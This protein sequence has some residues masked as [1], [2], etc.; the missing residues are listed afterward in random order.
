MWLVGF[1][2][3][4]CII[5]SISS[6]FF[7]IAWTST[8]SSLYSE[9]WSLNTALYWSRCSSVRIAGYL[10]QGNTKH[11]D[12]LNHRAKASQAHKIPSCKFSFKQIL[13]RCSPAWSQVS[14]RVQLEYALSQLWAWRR[15][16][17]CAEPPRRLASAP[18]NHQ[19]PNRVK[20]R[21]RNYQQYS[22]TIS[23]PDLSLS[24][25][26]LRFNY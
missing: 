9:Y 23:H 19:Q 3:K 26:H 7:S 1:C 17:V 11:K 16:C 4:F 22:L 13:T 2:G 10:L 21:I 8:C 18:L 25:A 5:T 6:N 15:Q 20:R 12:E 24:P 14:E